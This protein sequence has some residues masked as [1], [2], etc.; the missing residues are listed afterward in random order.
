MKKAIIII[1]ISI[2]AQTSFADYHYASHQGSNEYPYTSWATA[3]HLIQDAV[4]AADRRDTIFVGA[5]DYYQRVFLHTDSL[6]LVGMGMDSTRIW[7]DLFGYFIVYVDTSAA[8]SNIEFEHTGNFGNIIDPSIFAREMIIENCRFLGGGVFGGPKAIIRNCIFEGE[9]SSVHNGLPDRYLEVTNCY[10]NVY[11][12]YAIS[13][14]ADT[15]IILSNIINTE[16][17]TGISLATGNY[18]ANNLV[19]VRLAP[20]CIYMRP[21]N[22]GLCL[23][24]NTLDTTSTDFQI[25]GRGIRIIG[26]NVSIAMPNNDIVSGE[27][28]AVWFGG[29]NSTLYASYNNIWRAPVDFVVDSPSSHV[30][31]SLGLLHENPMYMGGNDYHL[32]EFSPLIDAGDPAIL[33]VDGSRSDIGCYGG[34]GGESYAYIDIPPSIPDSLSASIVAD[35]IILVWRFN[36]EADFSRYQLHRDTISGFTPNVFNMIAEPDTSYYVDLDWLPGHNYYYRIAAV[37]N[38]DNISDYSEELVVILTSIWGD[39]GVE[40]P[41]ITA[42]TGNYPNPFNS[43]TTIVYYVA[44]IGPIPARINIDI[45][46]IMG[47]KV[48]KLVDEKKEV[49]QHT[50]TWDGR[51]DAGNDLPTGVYFAR[52]SQWGEPRLSS[53]R[54]LVLLR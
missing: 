44:N 18:V 9:H 46:D 23:V 7:Y 32:Q 2:S 52:I 22:D 28:M 38:Q 13:S 30:D 49:G 40:R 36:P 54:K 48:R 15:N 50:I 27:D 12:D 26:E 35:S 43:Q 4:D 3:A 19:V 39:P 51:D 25:L 33:D 8:I 42:I 29:Y 10:I 37:D 5:G 21:Q 47:R 11:D 16:W 24:N 41:E 17:G 45:Y 31:T 53:K 1:L 14:A 34:P 20:Q 6:S